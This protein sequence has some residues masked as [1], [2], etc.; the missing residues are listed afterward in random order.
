MEKKDSTG[1]GIQSFNDILP[2][3]LYLNELEQRLETDPMLLGN[4]ADAS[5][6]LSTDL[7]CFTCHMCFTCELT[8]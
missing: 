3:D 2:S 1:K 5:V 7:D 8:V 6:Q 4:P